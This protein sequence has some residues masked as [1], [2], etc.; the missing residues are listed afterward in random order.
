MVGVIV[1]ET[2]TAFVHARDVHDPVAR[3]VAGDLHVADEGAGV[4]HRY[5]S[6]HVAPLSVEW[7]T[8]RRLA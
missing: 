8:K 6:V 1:G 3:Q 7:V 4:G 2:T 5:R